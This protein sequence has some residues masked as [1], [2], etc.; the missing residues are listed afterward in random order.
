MS[1]ILGAFGVN[2]KLLAIQIVNFGIVLAVLYFFVYRKIIGILEERQAIIAKGLD[3]AKE[4][5]ERKTQAETERG[6]LIAE[7]TKA[8][9]R[10]VEDASKNARERERSILHAANEA[11][12]EA[13]VRAQGEAERE[14]T[15]II[16]G[17]RGE[18]AKIATLAAAKILKER[19]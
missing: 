1:E 19:S 12:T 18:L 14:K 16:E 2:W 6:A 7:A 4:A 15:R 3:D 11:G 13:L 8:G 10:I 17:A 9:E 5:A